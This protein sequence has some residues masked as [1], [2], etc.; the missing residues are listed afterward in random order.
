MFANDTTA[1]PYQ[2]HFTMDYSVAETVDQIQQPPA[3]NSDSLATTRI[4]VQKIFVPIISMLGLFGNLLSIRVLTHRSMVSSTNCYLT[5]LA[6]FD[7]LYVVFSFTLSLKHYDAIK[8]DA[9]Y[10][11][12]FPVGRVLTDICSN[13]S[14]CL[15]VTFSLERLVAVSYPMKG[16][17]LCTPKRAR[18]ITAVVVIFAIL[19]TTPEFFE[20]K[21]VVTKREN[22][23]IVKQV[24]S[25]M[26]KTD[27]YRIGYYNFFVFTFTILPLILLSTFNGMLLKTVF[28]AMKI[29]RRMIY[30]ALRS[31]KGRRQTEQNR[32]TIMLIIVVIVFL[33]C[34][35]P[36]AVLLLYGIY[37]DTNS[38][39]LSQNGRNRMRI[40]GNIVNLLVLVNASI[41]FVLY[42]VMSTKFRK[43]CARLLRCLYDSRGRDPV[44]DFTTYNGQWVRESDMPLRFRSLRRCNWNNQTTSGVSS[45]QK[46]KR[47]YF[48]DKVYE[49]SIRTAPSACNGQ[50][51]SAD[52]SNESSDVIIQANDSTTPMVLRKLS[53]TRTNETSPC[54]MALGVQISEDGGS[55]SKENTK[56]GTCAIFQA[57]VLQIQMTVKHRFSSHSNNMMHTSV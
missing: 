39:T 13:V 53:K 35:F 20:T 57:N 55:A 52:S 36:Y 11:Y 40:A 29:R 32:I 21:L 45:H 42:S 17:V 49:K 7:V 28:A 56:P 34:Q 6:I 31:A 16:R 5:A 48:S 33:I 47:V 19:C 4:L 25:K 27:G 41:N 44:T 15:T 50:S 18:L 54:K 46:H 9:V 2:D 37:L 24:P 22:V 3:S 12:W 10:N 14:V 43:V 30:T 26:A 51:N 1:L 23:T 8:A 38:I